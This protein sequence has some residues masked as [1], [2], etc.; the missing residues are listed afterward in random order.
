MKEL[1]EAFLKSKPM[2]Q[3]EQEMLYSSGYGLYEAGNYEEATHLFTRLVLAD[4]FMETYWRGLA[5]CHQMTRNYEKALYAWALSSLLQEQDPWPHFHAAECLLSLNEK[6]EALK[7]LN[8]AA[9]RLKKEDRDHQSL[10]AKIETLKEVH[11]GY[12]HCN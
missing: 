7:A 5:S 3:E 1:Q 12:A 11:L 2:P 9:E 6:E 4:P 10:K 8:A